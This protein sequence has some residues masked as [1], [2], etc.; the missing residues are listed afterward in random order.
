[1]WRVG[2]SHAVYEHQCIHS[3]ILVPVLIQPHCFATLYDLLV[4]SP[5]FSAVVCLP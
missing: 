5:S 2:N 1:M 3:A 4:E